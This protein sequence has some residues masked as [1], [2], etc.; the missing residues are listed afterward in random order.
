MILNSMGD[1]KTLSD[2]LIEKTKNQTLASIAKAIGYSDSFLSKLRAGHYESAGINVAIDLSLYFHEPLEKILALIGKEKYYE[3]LKR[4]LAREFQKEPHLTFNSPEGDYE[5][6]KLFPDPISLGPGYELSEMVPEDYAPLLKSMLPKGWKSDKDRI[7]AFRTKGISMKPTINDGS[8][9][10]IDRMDV[11]PKIGEVYAFLLKDFGNIVTIKRLIKIDRHFMII[12]GDNSNA[13]DRKAE[14][15][16]DF[17]MV[18]NLKEY[19]H[20]GVSPVRGRVIWVLNRL[21]EK[22]KK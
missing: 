22:P 3:K 13:E 6:I 2:F 12:D 16:K 5:G 14:D 8:I 17:P 7:V 20:D 15:L 11:V 18:L 1:P 21:I 9:V 4:N 10:W 19:E